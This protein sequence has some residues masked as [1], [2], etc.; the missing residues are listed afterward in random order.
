MR[1]FQHQCHPDDFQ[2]NALGAL[3]PPSGASV[4]LS[5]DADGFWLE[6]NQEGFA[7]LARFF[8]E[9]ADSDLEPGW[10]THKAED[11]TSSTG[12]PEFTFM[13]VARR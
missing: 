8:A 1:T 10:H 6:A 11:F 4:K 9:I 2:H 12:P 7:F 5:C 13:L 3:S